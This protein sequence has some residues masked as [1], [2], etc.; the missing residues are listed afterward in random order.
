MKLIYLALLLLIVSGCGSN[1][2][3]VLV[4][5]FTPVECEDFGQIEP[6]KTLPVVFVNAVDTEGNQVLG[7]RGDQ[8][9]NL[10]IVFRRTLNYIDRQNKAIDYYKKC[11]SIHNEKAL[12]NEGLPE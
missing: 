1:P 10:S 4:P 7:L 12:K 5:I 8:Y 11:I 6:V 2:E 3:K 9:S